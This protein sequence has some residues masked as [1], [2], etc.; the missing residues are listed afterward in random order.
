MTER[1]TQWGS[2][3]Y[4]NEKLG[5]EEGEFSR[6]S[7]FYGEGQ[8]IPIERKGKKGLEVGYRE[9]LTVG[10]G[11]PFTFQDVYV[12]FD[13]ENSVTEVDKTTVKYEVKRHK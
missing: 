12:V 11:K 5:V 7:H 1:Q 2:I 3:L 4:K 6:D 8:E 13:G 9:P 10:S